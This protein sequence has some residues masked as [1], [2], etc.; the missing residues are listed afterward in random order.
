MTS[1]QIQMMKLKTTLMISVKLTPILDENQLFRES[2]N[3][4]KL[5]RSIEPLPPGVEGPT[6]MFLSLSMKSETGA[7]KLI[8]FMSTFSKGGVWAKDGIGAAKIR[9]VKRE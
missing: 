3:P 1:S 9:R 4:L 7:G 2:Q 6:F 8:F 5:E